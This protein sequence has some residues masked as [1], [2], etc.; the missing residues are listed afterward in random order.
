MLFVRAL[1]SY[2]RCCRLFICYEPFL[3]VQDGL[4]RFQDIRQCP[5]K[6]TRH[7]IQCSTVVTLDILHWIN[8][9]V[10]AVCCPAIQNGAYYVKIVVD[11]M[12]ILLFWHI[13]LSFNAVLYSSKYILTVLDYFILTTRN[14]L[15]TEE[16]P[17]DRERWLSMPLVH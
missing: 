12:N 4:N 13:R 16:I 2:L 8:C 3:A 1:G 15:S 5:V 11:T 6:W 17:Y 10:R 14:I 7:F 9:C